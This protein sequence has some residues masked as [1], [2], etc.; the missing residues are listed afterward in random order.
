MSMHNFQFA[1]VVVVDVVADVEVFAVM[2]PG[3]FVFEKKYQG[4]SFNCS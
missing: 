1:E 4:S 2:Q 3:F